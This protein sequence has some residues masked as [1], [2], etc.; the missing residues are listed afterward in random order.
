[1][2]YLLLL[3]AVGLVIARPAMAQPEPQPQNQ[4]STTHAVEATDPDQIAAAVD[5]MRAALLE[6]DTLSSGLIQTFA[7]ST[8]HMRERTLSSM[9][10]AQ[11]TS[12]HQQALV[13]YYD[14]LPSLARDMVL[15]ALPSAIDTNAPRLAASFSTEE[16]REVATFLRTP[17]GREIFR[18]LVLSSF[19]GTPQEISPDAQRELRRFVQT[20]GGRAFTERGQQLN[21]F[22][23]EAARDA[24]NA[25]GP[26]LL[27]RI[28]RDMCAVIEDQC[29]EELRRAGQVTP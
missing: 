8:A 26:S 24:T 2:R 9:L 20:A 28:S 10:Y 11:L 14:S 5:L 7:S 15:A 17:Q 3:A 16:L 29:T 6:T 25:I 21:S 1:M 22:L 18:N 19:P 27:A 12:A 13:R 4:A 23:I